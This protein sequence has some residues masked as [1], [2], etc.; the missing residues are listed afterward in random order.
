[1]YCIVCK[2]RGILTP[3]PESAIHLLVSGLLHGGKFLFEFVFKEFGA[4]MW[5]IEILPINWQAEWIYPPTVVISKAH[6]CHCHVHL[7]E[8][9]C[10]QKGYTWVQ[11]CG[12]NISHKTIIAASSVPFVNLKIK[13][14]SE[15][16]SLFDRRELWSLQA[17]N[18][19][20]NTEHE[21]DD[22][23]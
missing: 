4:C 17:S 21:G 9:I 13:N 10:M 7:V 8:Y 1:M 15:K 18:R 22:S 16:G 6:I 14:N 11:V 12:R 2:C 23:A 20:W 19:W 5:L 3:L